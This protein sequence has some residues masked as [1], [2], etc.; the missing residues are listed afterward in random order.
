MA[1]RGKKQPEVTIT[2]LTENEIDFT[3]EHVDVSVANALRR[4]LI[5]DVSYWRLSLLLITASSGLYP[6]Y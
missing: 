1:H 3:L 6:G 4:A 2:R 5:A